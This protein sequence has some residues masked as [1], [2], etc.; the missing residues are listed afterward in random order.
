MTPSLRTLPELDV[1]PDGS[2]YRMAWP[3]APGGVWQ[4]SLEACEAAARS[5]YAV[6][7]PPRGAVDLRRSPAVPSRPRHR[8]ADDFAP[9]ELMEMYGK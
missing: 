1:T 7:R 2:G 4:P 6:A 3:G 8:P 9:G 5:I